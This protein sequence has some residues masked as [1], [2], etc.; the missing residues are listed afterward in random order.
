MYCS[1]VSSPNLT[2]TGPMVVLFWDGRS[3]SSLINDYLTDWVRNGSN[4]VGDSF[5]TP[6]F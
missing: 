6:L 5:Y 2:Q 3:S 1:D 4:G